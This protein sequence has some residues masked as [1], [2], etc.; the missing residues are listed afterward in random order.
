[1]RIA[2]LFLFAVPLLA[3]TFRPLHVT[4][5]G[6]VA[7]DSGKPALLRGLNRGATGSGNADAAA[8]DS[9]YAAQNQLLSINLVRVFVNAAWWNANLPVP[10]ANQPY[11]TYIDTLIQR[12]KKYGNYVVILKA[13]QFPDPPCGAD[14]KNCPAPNQGDLNCQANSSLCLAQDT[15]GN[16]IDAAFTFWAAFAKKYAADPAVLYDTWEDMHG[17]DTNTWS[18]N[19]NQLIA[20]IRTWAPRSATSATRLIASVSSATPMVAMAVCS[21]GSS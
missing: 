19:Q 12:A 18:D 15:T 11:Q 21:A 16:S 13:G 6:I 2:F 10:I 1:M 14:G 5:S 4:S 20:A 8:T 7:D 17:I 9:D 3:Q